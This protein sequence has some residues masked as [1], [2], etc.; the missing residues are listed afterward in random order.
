MLDLLGR[1][2]LEAAQVRVHPHLLGVD[3][4]GVVVDLGELGHPALC[5]SEDVAPA[6]SDPAV[7]IKPQEGR[8]HPDT[9]AS[10]V[11]PEH[12]H[13]TSELF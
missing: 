8:V 11:D 10:L 5:P 7:L 13:Q 6:P 2:E 1:A 12:Q 4:L 9:A 3:L